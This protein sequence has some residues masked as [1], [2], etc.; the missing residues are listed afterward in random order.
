MSKIA[1]K[2]RKTGREQKLQILKIEEKE[3]G[4]NK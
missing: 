4:D 2:K 3:T 1:K